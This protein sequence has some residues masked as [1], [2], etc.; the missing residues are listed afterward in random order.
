MAL[1]DAVEN[2]QEFIDKNLEKSAV[3][4]LAKCMDQLAEELDVK[5]Y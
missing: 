2:A 4:E 5:T 3:E 1:K